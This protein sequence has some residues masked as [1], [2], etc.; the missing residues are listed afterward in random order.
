VHPLAK[1]RASSSRAE[2]SPVKG[3][4]G[5]LAR[6]FEG[7]QPA[8]LAVLIAGSTALLAVPR[9]VDPVDLPEP[10]IDLLALDRAA[11][12]DEALAAQAERERLDV[13]VLELGSAI[14]AYG[15]ADAAGDNLALARAR[16]R[17]LEAAARASK[18]GAPAI[19]A[20]RAHHLR[21][22]LLEVRRWERTGEESEKLQQLAGGFPRMVR[23]S[24]WLVDAGSR[25]RLLMD[26][27]VLAASFKKRWNEVIGLH[28]E[29]FDL[30]LDEARIFYRFLLLHPIRSMEGPGQYRLK[31][32]EELAAVDPSFPAHLARG[33]VLFQL[34]RYPLAVESFRR[35]LDASPDGP[36]TLR[37]QNYLRAAL[38]RARED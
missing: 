26:R 15:E 23:R 19:L 34:Q 38:G 24:G 30:T 5:G 18:V 33:V 16:G 17:V 8:A 14:F 28:G 13:D 32:I 3:A 1:S 31:K 6:H 25:P 36:M 22:F 27:A 4:V 7:W 9:P 2:R 21:S 35:H 10:R 12:A 20:L 11:R 29:P 37:A